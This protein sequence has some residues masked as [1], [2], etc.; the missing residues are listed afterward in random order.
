MAHF[1]AVLKVSLQD[2]AN[3]VPGETHSEFFSTPAPLLWANTNQF[4]N[5]GGC[6]EHIHILEDSHMDDLFHKYFSL[7]PTKDKLEQ[8]FS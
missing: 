2:A 1:T 4:Q 8:M 7:L 6:L 3:M 5:D